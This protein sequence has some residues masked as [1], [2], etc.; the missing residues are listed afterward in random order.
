MPHF[1]A[2]EHTLLFLEQKGETWVTVGLSLGKWAV[3]RNGDEWKAIAPAAVGM[4]LVPLPSGETK[5][6]PE[7]LPV[8]ELEKRLHSDSQQSS[9]K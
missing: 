9:E 6:L 7:S 5:A 2:N 3:E 4:R 8:R 1:E